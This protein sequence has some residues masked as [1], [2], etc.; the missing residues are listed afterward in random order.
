MN[1]SVDPVTPEESSDEASFL[2]E[3]AH[4]PNVSPFA[5]DLSG[6]ML[7]RY[8]VVRRLG[9]GGMGVV[10]LAE[11]QV[12]QR[13]VALKVLPPHL[14]GDA[15]KRRHLLREA[16]S[17]A[18]AAHAGIAAVFDIQEIDEHVV[19][20]M[21]RIEGV[22][23][24]ERILEAKRGGGLSPSEILKI[25]RQLA[26]ALAHAHKAGVIHRDLK[27]ENV[28]LAAGDQVKILDFG[29]AKLQPTELSSSASEPTGSV[30]EQHAGTPSYMAPE[31]ARG[32]FDERSDIFSFGVILYELATGARPFTGGSRTEVSF[33]IEHDTPRPPSQLMSNISPALEA[34]ILGCLAKKP[35]DRPP[36]GEVLCAALDSIVEPRAPKKKAVWR[37][38]AAI[39]VAAAAAYLI[40]RSG[41]AP[42]PL[43]T[44][45]TA[46]ACPLLEAGGVTEP[47]GWLGAAAGSLICARAR[48]LAGGDASVVLVPAALL[49]LPRL[50]D[51]NFP[52]DPYAAPDARSRSLAAAR[53][54]GTAYFDGSVSRTRT[55]FKVVLEL[56]DATARLQQSGEGEGPGL[57]SAVRAAMDHFVASG[58]L[59]VAPALLPEV[60]E[61]EGLR[62]P[63][64]YRMVH[65]RHLGEMTNEDQT[66]ALAELEPRAAE[67]GTMWTEIQATLADETGS[68]W[69]L[70]TIPEIDRSSPAAFARTAPLR[71]QL[72]GG[73]GSVELAEEASR[74][75]AA[76]P[77]LAGRAA[78]NLAEAQ[79]RGN[80]DSG[81]AAALVLAAVADD[82]TGPGLALLQQ[83][84][85]G[86]A[87]SSG[88]HALAAW[89]PAD[90]N[91]WNSLAITDVNMGYEGFRRAQA[92]GTRSPVY[93]VHLSMW[94]IDQERRD[95][96]RALVADMV[97]RSATAPGPEGQVGVR[98]VASE[99]ILAQ[100]EASEAQIGA[101]IDRIERALFSLPAFGRGSSPE[102]Y[103][104]TMLM[105]LTGVLDR[106]AEPAER[107]VR[108]FVDP[109]PPKL[110]GA[111][112]VPER[113]ASV[114]AHAPEAAAK[115][116]FAKLRTLLAAGFF[117]PPLPP[118]SEPFIKG[119]EAYSRRDWVAATNAWRPLSGRPGTKG[120]H[121]LPLAFDRAGERE[122]AE[123][124]DRGSM[125]RR[126]PLNGVGFAHV[127]SA[128][129][130][131]ELGDAAR[132][133]ALARQVL[134]A[135]RE[136]DV[137]IPV[138]AKL[139]ALL[140]SRP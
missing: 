108:T 90:A 40:Q 9:R 46:L 36:S 105:E 86:A 101:A 25:S 127:R 70:I 71:M 60:A 130:A 81:R 37:A 140:S 87:R 8:H 117:R 132:A 139:R 75:A 50:P 35:E 21:E 67:L 111:P 24:R 88:A 98:L 137:P 34:L 19:I 53:A 61:W 96:T 47:T 107:F 106:S 69:A 123:T 68:G 63:Q 104:L 42:A 134:D 83:Y 57:H 115:R 73:G 65:D 92:L 59:A 13:S 126:K 58:A 16:R 55:G 77:S 33:A 84:S 7:G 64:L 39:A 11:D 14:V 89:Q 129:R 103:L 51:D 113:V 26:A 43:L 48:L 12:L 6:R 131:A 22:T 110:Y 1:E 29:L 23:L 20:A 31:Q 56:R 18:R 72:L 52:F 45:G 109:D 135:W 3:A 125:Q 2:R 62:D 15:R 10:Y 121:L 91:A 116:C 114:C 80:T 49:D 100:I 99:L 128:L 82:P 93:A 38:A 27:P 119:A 30:D 95:E 97:S 32:Q 94:L 85:S 17:A 28:M 4:A 54:R 122:L 79:L 133:Q 102:I 138:S 5:G 120:S 112:Y 66:R 41:R 74:L 78:L 118:D 136:A 76:E 124:I 44:P